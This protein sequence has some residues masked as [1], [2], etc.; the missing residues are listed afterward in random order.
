[1]D[2]FL[3]DMRFAV[4]ALRQ[5]PGL[6]AI[7]V[8]T[9]ALGIGA[10]AAIFTVVNAVVLRPLP[11][12][13]A[14]RL[15]RLTADA[16][17]LNAHDI[18]MSPPE[19][20]DYRD[21]SDVFEEIAGVFPINA[22]LTEVDVPERIEVLLVSPSYFS[23]LGA[24]AELGR[25]F[26]EQDFHPGIAELVI[27]S[28]GL[29]QRR[30]GGRADVLGR[31]LRIDGD[32]F[33]IVGVM[34]PEFRHPGRSLRV[35]V[36]MWSPS[37]FSSTPY[38]P[39]EKSRGAY[40]L[41]GA[42]GRLKPGLTLTQ[43]RQRLEAFAAKVR[44]EHPADYPARAGWT[45]RIFDLREDL[46][47][48]RKMAIVLLQAAV[49]LV[50]LIACAN[51]AGLLLAR[52]AGRQR[53][54]SIRRALGAGRARLSRLLLA[55]SL[56]ISLCGGVAGLL[57]AIWGLDL[58]MAL[59]PAN[60]P[61]VSEIAINVR[62]VVFCGAVAVATGLLI[63]IAPSLQ[64]SKPDVLKGLSETQSRTTT[65]RGSV[66]SALVVCEIA[67]AMVLLVGAALLT[68]SFWQL[69]QVDAGFT[70][71][72]VLSARLWLPQPN[73]PS[74]GRYFT[75]QARLTF[76]NEVLRRL[77]ALPG[78]ESAAIVQNLP[79][80]GQ[81]GFSTITI[82]GQESDA[83]GQIPSVQG[84]MVSE[85]YFA[86]MRIP[87]RRGRTFTAIDQMNTDRVVIV[88]DELA[89]RYF[90]GQDP[91]GQRLHFGAPRTE[92]PWLTIVGVVGNV[93]SD[94]LEGQT[95]PTVYRPLTQASS[96]S[97]AVAL[98]ASGDPAALGVPLTRVVREVDPD[99]PTFAVRTM[100]QVH[101]AAAASRRFSMQ[102]VGSFALLALLLAAI[103]IYG[104]MAY[105][106][107]ERTREIGIRVALG[108][109][110]SEVIRMV[111]GRAMRLAL[112]GVALG[113]AAGL[114][115]AQ[116]ASNLLFRVSAADPWAF[117]A[118]AVVLSLTALAA[119]AAPATRAARVDP[120]VALRAE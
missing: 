37:G 59:M 62:V 119:A 75:H 101:A 74:T 86:L 42:I 50:L 104:V 48:G 51:V 20:F 56:V 108:A 58:I 65:S 36:E 118:I 35:D 57:F 47:G 64:F 73:D 55:E 92:A 77:R 5:H 13:A 113:A 100:D 3:Q 53:E 84:N 60:M 67:L 81:R 78:V 93:L 98:R 33:T 120:I 112:A 117:G 82:A 29:W 25:V 106:V 23:V 2:A 68:R 26:N 54:L 39:I 22:N 21:R 52:A 19:L 8:A 15:V 4:R 87:L 115:G 69:Q 16:P 45:P 90:A 110:Q 79:L 14:D 17:G 114:A 28:H 99:Q 71:R 80:D 41:T 38:P 102:L 107:S 12:P 116:L 85:D 49:G 66:R 9:L 94:T 95:R 63:G 44:A 11:F 83:V 43:A 111:V 1:M 88:N 40:F 105:L 18:G 97:M 30:F 7:V 10:N 89:Q 6:S 76:F 46:I 103:G 72:G 109:R 24:H 96:L 70:G 32:W 27:V 34:P 61:R 31:K 91:V